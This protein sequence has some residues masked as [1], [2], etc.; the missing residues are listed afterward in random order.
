MN[1]LILLLTGLTLFLSATPCCTAD[2]ENATEHQS[3]EESSDCENTPC[4]E[5]CSP[6]FTCGSCTGFS[7]QELETC[8]LLQEQ[9]SLAVPVSKFNLYREDYHETSFKPP[10]ARLQSV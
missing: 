6:F 10:R 4:D 3:C 9:V 2:F 1:V 8:F 7:I 5:P